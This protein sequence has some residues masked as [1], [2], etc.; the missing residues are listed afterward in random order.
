MLEIALMILGGIL[1]TVV[2]AL[3]FG[4]IGSNHTKVG[5]VTERE[6]ASLSEAYGEPEPWLGA[7]FWPITLL[8]FNV[9]IPL[10]RIGW[11]KG[12][13]AKNAKRLRIK[14]E[15]KIRISQEELEREAE[16]EVEEL[17]AVKTKKKDLR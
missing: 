11:V 10:T 1:Y 7:I 8:L 3:T 4:Y 16:E 14:I 17:L 6:A 2:G 5:Y 15:E 12:E 13:K 9:L